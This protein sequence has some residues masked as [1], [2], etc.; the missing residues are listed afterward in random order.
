[1]VRLSLQSS[2][3][4]R[5]VSPAVLLVSVVDVSV[6]KLANDKT[7]RA[8]PTHFLLTSEVRRA[9]DLENADFFM[10]AHPKAEFGLDLLLGV[11]GWRRFAEQDPARFA[12]PELAEEK[13][14]A[15]RF[16]QAVA[17]GG[18]QKTD[19]EKD[20]VA[21]IDVKYV[22]QFV[23]MQEKLGSAENL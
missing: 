7:H 22:P 11:Q 8:M 16:L 9:E 18:M 17:P 20:S 10:G 2:T 1:K 12:R 21:A 23:R 6:G 19:P 5:E 3:E 13:L 4:K 14:D 15:V